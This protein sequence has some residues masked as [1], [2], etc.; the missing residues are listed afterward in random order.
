MPEHT[1]HRDGNY[2]LPLQL[3]QWMFPRRNIQ[4]PLKKKKWLPWAAQIISSISHFRVKYLTI[5]VVSHFKMHLTC[6][7]QPHSSG[8]HA[9][10]CVQMY[11]LCIS[12]KYFVLL[13]IMMYTPS[14]FEIMSISFWNYTLD[15]AD[16]EKQLNRYPSW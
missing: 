11:R 14:S 5:F 13:P 3:F 6:I 4:L 2:L 1:E 15:F 8:I 7:T 10:G 12:I 9:T 16:E